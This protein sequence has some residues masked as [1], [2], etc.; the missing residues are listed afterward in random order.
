MKFFLSPKQYNAIH[1][2]STDIVITEKLPES[3]CVDGRSLMSI[4]HSLEMVWHDTF[5]TMK[6][7]MRLKMIESMQ[8]LQKIANKLSD[9]DF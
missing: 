6:P 1:S 4:Y 8:D 3:P 7:E 9:G 5:P 2:E